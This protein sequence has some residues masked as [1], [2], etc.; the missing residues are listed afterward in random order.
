MRGLL[1]LI[2]VASAIS[3][4]PL[5]AQGRARAPREPHRRGAQ[6]KPDAERGRDGRLDETPHVRNNH[7]YGHAAP[8][9]GR[10]HLEHPFEHGRF[11]GIGRS[12]RYPVVRIDR[13]AHR[14]WLSGG[15]FFEIASWDW[16]YA[17]AWCWDCGDDF[18]IYDD[19][20]H[21]GW[22]LVLDVRTGRYVHAL[23]LG[24]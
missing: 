15:F 7:W 18:A 12:H 8:G 19:P 17:A 20:D 22:Y 11:A 10:F 13:D 24:T 3:A 16:P 1:A 4:A 5:A 6:A 21:V 2:V 23:F 9:D 14:F